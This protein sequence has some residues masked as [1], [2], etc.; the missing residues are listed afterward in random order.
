MLSSRSRSRSASSGA[1]VDSAGDRTCTATAPSAVASATELRC[2]CTSDA[3]DA[4]NTLAPLDACSTTGAASSASR[5]HACST[6]S[7]SSTKKTAGRCA[8][9]RTRTAPAHTR[10]HALMGGD[11]A[12]LYSATVPFSKP[13][14]KYAVSH[15]EKCSV[16]HGLPSQPSGASNVRTPSRPP[17]RLPCTIR[18]DTVPTRYRAGSVGQNSTSHTLGPTPEPLTPPSALSSPLPPSDASESA[19]G[20]RSLAGDPITLTVPAFTSFN[21]EPMP[22]PKSVSE[23]APS[24]TVSSTVTQNV[25]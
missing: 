20:R 3:S 2:D 13:A 6:C 12:V 4:A 17:N 5:S 7:R 18:P 1:A 24:R 23:T 9:H 19:R 14:R 15:G 10:S 22:R 21:R 11:A 16:V 25:R 8:D